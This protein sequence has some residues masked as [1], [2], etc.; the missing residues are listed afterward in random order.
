[1][2]TKT[3]MKKIIALILAGISAV[4]LVY[5]VHDWIVHGVGNMK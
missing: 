3:P 4:V 5:I 2:K 1:M